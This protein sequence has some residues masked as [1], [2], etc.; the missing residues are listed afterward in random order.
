M[1]ST[2][3][4]IFVPLSVTENFKTLYFI[5]TEKFQRRHEDYDYIDD[6][7]FH[8]YPSDNPYFY[9]GNSD[10]THVAF[11]D[12]YD[13]YLPDVTESCSLSPTTSNPIPLDDYELQVAVSSG[14]E[15]L[16]RCNITIHVVDPLTSSLPTPGIIRTPSIIQ[17]LL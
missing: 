6:I 14:G 5:M 7:T 8:L 13:L 9:F 16:L 12:Y 1:D 2:L 4:E 10:T 15:E 17:M 3:Y 11:E